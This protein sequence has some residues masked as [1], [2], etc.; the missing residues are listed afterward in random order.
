MQFI[1]EHNTGIVKVTLPEMGGHNNSHI[2]RI[3]KAYSKYKSHHS[4]INTHRR[5][6]ERETEMNREENK[7]ISRSQKHLLIA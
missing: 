6:R 3:T 2:C 7:T 5:K 4:Y 1:E